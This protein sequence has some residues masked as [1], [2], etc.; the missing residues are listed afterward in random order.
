MT[1]HECEFKK[2]SQ[3]VD[4]IVDGYGNY[5][6][7]MCFQQIPESCVHPKFRK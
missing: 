3:M 4:I 2:S 7:A 1:E 5:F 6:C